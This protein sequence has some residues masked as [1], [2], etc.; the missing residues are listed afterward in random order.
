VT[1]SPSREE[2]RLRLRDLI[3]G[4]CSRQ[5]VSDW[6]AQ[7]LAAD[8]PSVEDDVV[9]RA[10]VGLGAANLKTGP[11]EYLY[12]EPDFHAWLD[13]VEDAIDTCQ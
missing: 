9:W 3:G 4:K 5:D 6:A 12:Y 13:D 10:L 2:M 11:N 1:R 8:Y 7:W